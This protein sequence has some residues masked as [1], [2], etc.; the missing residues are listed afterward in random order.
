MTRL[1]RTI[2][3]PLSALCALG[4]SLTG[5]QAQ[6]HVGALPAKATTDP[7]LTAL[8]ASTLKDSRV[9]KASVGVVVADSV[10]GSEYYAQSAATALTPASNMKLVTAAA[11]LDLLGTDRR[12]TTGVYAAAA[13]VK[14]T[15]SRLYLRGYGD[16]TLREGDLRSLAGQVK[17]AGVTRVTGS[18]VGDA[19]YF[20]DDRYHDNWDSTDYNYSYAPQISALTLS[21]SSAL[22]VGTI[23]VTYKPGS[24][25]GARAKLAVIPASAAGFVKLVNRTTT[26]RAGTGASISVRRKLHTNTITVSGRVA[27][28]RNLVKRVVTISNPARYAAHVFTR[29]LR[30][31]GVAVAGSPITGRTPATRVKLG[32]DSSATVGQI[33][34]KLMKSSNNGIAEHLVKTL[35]RAKGKAGTWAAGSARIRTWLTGTQTVPS[36][37]RIVDGSG[38]AH[39]NKLTARVLVQMLQYVRGRPWFGIFFD[40]LPVAGN[41]DSAIGGTLQS[42]MVGT[43]A[44]NNLRAKTGTL[45]GVTALSGYVTGRDGRLYTF[46][47]L[48]KYRG[49]SPRIVFDRLG[50]RL[51]AWPG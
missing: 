22:K 27:L 17:A 26:T 44:Q 49:S 6:A 13:P 47:M 38:L 5:G 3:V 16:P 51:A 31:A 8:I 34:P 12:F 42:R 32:T 48:G 41:S 28:K 2:L 30:S 33:V 23:L 37:V 46:S 19:G 25:P 36:T 43:A 1:P 9:T 39:R 40:S 11:A 18:V 7:A 50:A 10:S 45:N 15:V 20:D 29:V 35:G 21:P 14:G 24:S 4:L